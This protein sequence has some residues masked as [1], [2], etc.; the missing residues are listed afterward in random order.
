MCPIDTNDPKQLQDLLNQYLGINKQDTPNMSVQP[1]EPLMTPMN[2]QPSTD[3]Q[4]STSNDDQTNTDQ[5]DKTVSS[6]EAEQSHPQAP[7]KIPSQVPPQAP[8]PSTDIGS[9]LKNIN[10]GTNNVSTLAGLKEAQAARDRQRDTADI[11]KYGE[12]IG[13]GLSGRENKPLEDMAKTQ[14]QRSL[15]KVPDFEAQQEELKH[16]PNS[17]V[18]K[19]M[20]DMMKQYGFNISGDA[21]AADLEKA[22]PMLAKA[23]EAEQT[24][25]NQQEM[26]KYKYK[27][28]ATLAGLKGQEKEQAGLD[29]A[30]THLADVINPNKAR[31]GEMGKNQARLN[32]AGRVSALVDQYGNP[33]AI[34]MRELATTVGNMLTM[35]SQTAVQQINELVPHTMSGN[36][37]KIQEWLTNEPQGLDQQKFVK[38]YSD[39]A[40]REAKVAGDQLKDAQFTE[41]KNAAGNLQKK[42]PD[43]FY[44]QIGTATHMDPEEVKSIMEAK[45]YK[46]GYPGSKVAPTKALAP[47]VNEERR[48]TPDG[49]TAI[50]DATTHQFLRYE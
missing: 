50:F 1:T 3:D 43:A 42:R 31:S 16:D 13:R 4:S 35:G 39:I 6:P 28:L 11:M 41:A 45:G 15:E 30:E 21:S 32:A 40:N 8:N 5:T 38:M 48:Q 47:S 19:G 33:S 10:F 12:L 44:S 37:A 9:L 23:Y 14:E 26:L 24:R 27:E 29:K 2:Q 49:R 34:P 17:A 22:N 20:R 7:S 18:S 46:G 25:K 36:V